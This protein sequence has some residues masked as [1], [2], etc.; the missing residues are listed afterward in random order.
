MV[1][2]LE[3][4][5]VVAARLEICRLNPERQVRG[6]APQSQGLNPGMMGWLPFGGG[7]TLGV[8]RSV[9]DTVGLFDNTVPRNE[10]VD[11]CYRAQLNGF[12]IQFV[13]DAIVHY[14]MRPSARSIFQQARGSGRGIPCLYSKFRSAGMPRHGP[15]AVARFWLGGI[16]EC[17]RAR[18]RDD[19]LWCAGIIGLRIGLLEGSVRYRVFYL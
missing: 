10:D 2:A 15:S 14:R 8:R 19:L 17:L 6:D 18:S 16:R 13:P 11:F 3:R 9:L 4:S 5:L 1:A 12:S 7:A